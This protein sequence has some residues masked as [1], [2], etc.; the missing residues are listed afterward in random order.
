M[1]GDFENAVKEIIRLLQ[2]HD[3]GSFRSYAQGALIATIL[4]RG[5]WE[6]FKEYPFLFHGLSNEILLT[7][8]ELGA[9]ITSQEIMDSSRLVG[10]KN[11]NYITKYPDQFLHE[12]EQLVVAYEY[13]NGSLLDMVSREELEVAETSLFANVSI[14]DHI[15]IIKTPQLLKNEKFKA[16]LYSLLEKAHDSVKQKHSKKH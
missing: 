5:R 11:R 12:L 13:E 9:K 2:H 4:H 7:R 6:L 3:K 16:I 1:I 15:R 8:R 14:P 10:F